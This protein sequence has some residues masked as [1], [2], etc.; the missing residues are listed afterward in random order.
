[1]PIGVSA[2]APPLI[3]HRWAAGNCFAS[4]ETT[5]VTAD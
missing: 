4:L 2:F 5:A 1:M 3:G